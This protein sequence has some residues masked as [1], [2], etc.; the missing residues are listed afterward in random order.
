[1][2]NSSCGI[3]FKMGD[4][5]SLRCLF[6]ACQLF[7]IAW[8]QRSQMTQNHSGY[9]LTL[10]LIS[11]LCLPT[12]GECIYSSFFFYLFCKFAGIYVPFQGFHPLSNTFL[13]YLWIHCPMPLLILYHHLIRLH[14]LSAI[15]AMFASI[16]IMLSLLLDWCAS[17]CWFRVRTGTV[18]C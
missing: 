11:I 8:S 15:L 18:Q 13:I 14:Q 3:C 7:P 12:L 4:R 16:I 17:I 10:L 1:M 6:T 2:P 9:W 5:L